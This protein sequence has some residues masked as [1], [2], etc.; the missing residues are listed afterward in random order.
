[1]KSKEQNSGD[2]I[3]ILYKEQDWL[4]GCCD[5]GLIHKYH[6]TIDPDDQDRMLIQ[7]WRMDELTKKERARKKKSKK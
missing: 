7:G 2:V 3:T 4:L 1:M 5:C 6:F